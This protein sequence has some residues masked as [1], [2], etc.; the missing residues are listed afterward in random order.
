MIRFGSVR[1]APLALLGALALALL[2]AGPATAA[3]TPAYS[4]TDLGA[5][6]S[7]QVR[8]SGINASGEVVG[9]SAVS[10]AI[11]GFTW[12]ATAGISEIPDG[13]ACSAA[14][15]VNRGGV[16][17]GMLDHSGGA[18]CYVAITVAPGA[19]AP[20]ELGT[21]P[22]DGCSYGVSIND[23]GQV[24]GTSTTRD[25]ATT[26]AFV[27]TPGAGMQDLGNLGGN[28]SAASVNWLGVVTGTSATPTTPAGDHWN[29]GHAFVAFGG[30]GMADL[31]T[32]NF[33]A[34]WDLRTAAGINSSGQIAGFGAHG[35]A[36]H[37]Y[38]YS[39]G[40]VTDLGT[41]PNGGISYALGLSDSGR[42]VGAAYLDAT[43]VGN[44]RAMTWTAAGGMQNLNGLIGPASSEWT[45]REATAVNGSGQIVGW[46]EHNGQVRAFLLTPALPDVPAVQK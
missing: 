27:F 16:V 35:G 18:G 25:G 10:C 7:G 21:L 26:H 40:Q 36:V 34:G 17:A 5:L 12:T 20:A 29:P 31:N 33:T 8:A 11:N 1:R 32:L 14:F 41:F 46:G 2:S 4:V 42:V 45:L 38:L 39:F 24:A 28:A 15:A 3:T 44:F 9:S 19:A 30:L 43:G 37:A 22:G 13:G 6:G 23:F